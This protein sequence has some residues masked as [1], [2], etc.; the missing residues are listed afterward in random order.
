[1]KAYQ[2]TSITSVQLL[3]CFTIP[4]VMARGLHA[5]IAST[6]RW[7]DVRHTRKHVA[8]FNFA[9]TLLLCFLRLLQGLS[10]FVLRS[11]FGWR[12]LTGALVQRR[13]AP[14]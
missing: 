8:L 11:R 4:C 9:L 12:H 13:A 5:P 7:L 1:M 6:E 14:G 3:D 10:V 2:F